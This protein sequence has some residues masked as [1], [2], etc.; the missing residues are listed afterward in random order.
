ML[1]NARVKGAKGTKRPAEPPQIDGAQAVATETPPKEVGVRSGD[2][3]TVN[4][5]VGVHFRAAADAAPE[6]GDL[7]LVRL[8]DG[9]EATLLCSCT[10]PLISGTV[11]VQAFTF[12]GS[13]E[14]K[15]LEPHK[16]NKARVFWRS[17][18]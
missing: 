6:P 11:L 10:K 12:A 9:A 1:R 2:E 15:L 8:P 18:E 3:V 14:Y 4:E 13:G 16:G 17:E 5:A 7:I